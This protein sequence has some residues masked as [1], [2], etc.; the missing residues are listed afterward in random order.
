VK[1]WPLYIVII[2]WIFFRDVNAICD[3]QGMMDGM[4]SAH[5]K[6]RS[7]V[8][9]P[10]LSWSDEL[11]GHAREWANYLAQEERCVV[12]HRPEQGRYFHGY[13]ENLY[14]A[15]AVVWSDGK[16]EPQDITPSHVVQNW[17]AERI[18]YSYETNSCRDGKSCGHYTQIVWQQTE[19]VG[20]ARAICPDKSQIWVCR[21]HPAGNSIGQKPYQ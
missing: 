18:N 19:Q 14:W 7:E 10:E 5:N 1:Q 8:G 17:A 21:Y 3:D 15:S 20:C 13:G 6:T 2:A 12:R 16:R 4:L 9:A 11:A